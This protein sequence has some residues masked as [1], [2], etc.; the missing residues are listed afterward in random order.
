MQ[1]V[2]FI[3]DP[4]AKDRSSPSADLS[5]G[6]Y[7][8]IHPGTG[9]ML[10]TLVSTTP[11]QLDRHFHSARQA[12]HAWSQTSFKER[13]IVFEEL[14]EWLVESPLEIAATIESVIGTPPADSILAELFPLCE[15]IR[16]LLAHGESVLASDE[17]PTGTLVHK[18]ATVSYSP[19]G[20]V[21]TFTPASLPLYHLYAPMLGA[22]YA[23]NAVITKPS[24]HV[25]WAAQVLLAPF[26]QILRKH[27]HS[28]DL[29][30][31][32]Q[33]DAAVGA[34]IIDRAPDLAIFIG[35]AQAGHAFVQRAGAA[36]VP[37]ISAFGSNDAILV[38]ND[39]NLKKATRAI[40]HGCALAGGQMPTR[41]GRV[42][43]LPDI[44]DEL[45]DSL[46][47]GLKR[48]AQRESHLGCALVRPGEAEVALSLIDEARRFGAQV[49]WGGTRSIGKGQRFPKTLLT[50]VPA[51]APLV[52]SDL[53]A[54]ILPIIRA[55]DEVE[56]VQ[57][58]NEAALG[59]ATTV[60]TES[61][62][63]AERIALTLRVG[64]VSI[65]EWGTSHNMATLPY[66]GSGTS[67][68]GRLYGPEGLRAMCTVKTI[69]SDRLA[70]ARP[71]F[72]DLESSASAE[73]LESTLKAIYAPTARRKTKAAFATAR[74]L[75]S[76]MKSKY[77]IAQKGRK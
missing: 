15:K 65:N 70:L 5:S 44:H 25:A 13:A 34:A 42:Y 16:F 7:Q 26:H 33:G 32:V 29:A 74:S 62:V 45:V 17:R 72:L 59:L 9:E 22:I 57:W 27:G 58:I 35:S 8:C 60:I 39:A 67:G 24:Q 49:R 14:L 11:A 50:D 30:T 76:L 10:G 3:P 48:D 61:H 37:V 66:G 40:L 19:A 71:D 47:V 41:V 21:A 51:N 4:A 36:N 12:Q 43:A 63:R 77:R 46:I 23:G 56:A 75:G 2:P 64:M 31:L 55:R 6:E 52:T 68:L 54:A 1:D 53:R 38:C 28:P 69:L 20:L 18:R 73:F